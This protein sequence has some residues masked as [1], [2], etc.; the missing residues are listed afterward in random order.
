MHNGNSVLFFSLQSYVSIVTHTKFSRL[1]IPRRYI[2]NFTTKI[3]GTRV[4]LPNAHSFNRPCSPRLITIVITE[5]S[6]SNF[7][8]RPQKRGRRGKKISLSRTII[9][10][11]PWDYPNL[12]RP[13][14][15]RSRIRETYF[16]IRDRYATP[17]KR[18]RGGEGVIITKILAYLNDASL[19]T[20][21]KV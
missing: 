3:R 16:V 19:H 4:F 20:G 9:P 18:K 17:S 15:V 13:V 5:A 1:S 6:F 8:P 10:R 11:F 2:I 12:R 7:A 21:L 14:G